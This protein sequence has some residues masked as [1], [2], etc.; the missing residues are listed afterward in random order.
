MSSQRQVVRQL[1]ENGGPLAESV[2]R[3][4]RKP[5]ECLTRERLTEMRNLL[6][7]WDVTVLSVE[8]KVLEAR[9]GSSR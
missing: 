5:D 2:S 4:V 6:T 1:I 3:I 9:N 7:N 8:P